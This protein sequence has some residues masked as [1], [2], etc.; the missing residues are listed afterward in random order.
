M[1]ATS[2]PPHGS[3]GPEVR[4]A[5]AEDGDALARLADELGY[6]SSAAQI[7]ARLELLRSRPDHWIGVAIDR[8]GAVL[9]WI[10]VG[11]AITLETGELAEILGLVVSSACRRAGV[12]RE[13]VSAAERWC[14]QAG[15]A[16]IT[17]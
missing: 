8:A 1:S 9:G 7:R 13:L 5:R 14:R 16:R 12:G 3:A 10:H 6:P 4:A 15:L 17:V 2:V 11:R